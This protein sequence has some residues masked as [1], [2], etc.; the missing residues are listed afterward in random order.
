MLTQL[1]E[2]DVYQ[3]QP[4]LAAIDLNSGK[5]T[6]LI[7]MPEQRDVQISLSPDGLALLLDQIVTSPDSDSPQINVPRTS[8]GE[9]ISTSRL[10]LAPL[11][12]PASVSTT[13][14]QI[15]PQQLPL[16]GFHPRWLP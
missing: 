9:A 13:A 10:W 3:E 1:I 14:N 7:V 16:P 15:Q 4:Y 6:P 11:F 12:S 8:D 2:G 5:Q